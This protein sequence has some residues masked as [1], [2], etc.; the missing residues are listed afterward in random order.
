MYCAISWPWVNGQSL[1]YAKR[2]GG[3][4]DAAARQTQGGAFT[5]EELAEQDVLVIL[6]RGHLRQVSLAALFLETEH[7]L[8]FATKDARPRQKTIFNTRTV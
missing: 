7:I 3:A 4:A 8:G 5:G 1:Q 6:R 2:K